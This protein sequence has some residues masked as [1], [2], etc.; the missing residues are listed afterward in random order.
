MWRIQQIR[1][2]WQQQEEEYW[3]GAAQEYVLDVPSEQQQQQ[4]QHVIPRGQQHG[5][6][7]AHPILI[8]PGFY[9]SSSCAFADQRRWLRYSSSF[10]WLLLH[11]YWGRM[12]C[13]LLFI[14]H[15]S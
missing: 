4:Q 5:A 6:L 3:L 2:Q 11:D 7:Y 8:V 9:S 10:A 14:G 12:R 15:G 1:K 13:I